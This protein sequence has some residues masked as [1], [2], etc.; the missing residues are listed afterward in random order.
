MILTEKEKKRIDK[1]HPG[2]YEESIEY[3]SSENGETYTYI[4]PRYWSLTEN[5][6]LTEEEVKSKKY[7]KVIPAKNEKGKT[8]TKIGEGEKIFEFTS[9]EH[10]D[11]NGDYV[12][13][14]PGF[15]K[16]DKNP[17]GKC[18]PCCFKTTKTP[19]QI[20][21]KKACAA[22]PGKEE[23]KKEVKKEAVK[24][25][26][27]IFGGIMGDSTDSSDSSDDKSDSDSESASNSD[28]DS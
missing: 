8:N 11:A 3:K 10:V 12:H 19:E 6:S 23:V 24:T 13:H 28:S 1:E 9:N 7:G 27:G 4:C 25:V 22:D 2:S 26:K 17:S 5:T 15:M 21:R 18:M 20:K 16:S 14:S